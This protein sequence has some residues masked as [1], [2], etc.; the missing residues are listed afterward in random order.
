MRILHCAD[1]H[2]DSRMKTH[3]DDA[4]AKQRRDELL[5]TFLRMMERAEQEKVQAVLIA[6]DL[7]DVRDVTKR[8][9]SAVLGCVAKYPGIQV[10]Y[11]KGNHDHAGSG[12]GEDPDLP[13]NLHYFGEDWTS[14]V[15]DESG[16]RRIVLYGAEL[17]KE[18]N[19]R[20]HVDL[21]VRQEDINIVM[22]HGQTAKLKKSGRG[23]IIALDR[24]KDLGID[25]LALGHVHAHT[26]E[27]L[28]KRGVMVYPGCLEGRGFDECGEHGF[29]LLDIDPEN[30]TVAREFIPF[31]KRRM[32]EFPVDISDCSDGNEIL[33]RVKT[34]WEEASIPPQDMVKLILTGEV[35]EGCDTDTG[36]ILQQLQ[37]RVYYLKVTDRTSEAIDEEKLAGERSLRGTY[38][39]MIRADDSLR[40]EEKRVLIRSGIL[41][42]S[43]EWDRLQSGLD[44]MDG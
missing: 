12:E 42:L 1:V 11:L 6:G 3:F 7:Y 10:Y 43:G 20:L 36:L 5:D 23:E 24:L 30:G 17:E 18:N 22:L 16:R 8:T 32:R 37:D 35:R 19:A 44:R 38:V 28:D 39:R 9:R 15:L 4:T 29:M 34:A 2:L 33:E 21:R 26:E 27:A 13:V 14:Y 31:S 41:A 40:E 25:Y